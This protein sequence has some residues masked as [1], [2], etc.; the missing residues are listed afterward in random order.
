MHPDPLQ[1]LPIHPVT[2]SEEKNTN[3]KAIYALNN[4]QHIVTKVKSS[5]LKELLDE[6]FYARCDKEIHSFSTMY[7][8]A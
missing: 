7:K 2:P 6:S 4:I 1:E 8:T 5:N 3:V